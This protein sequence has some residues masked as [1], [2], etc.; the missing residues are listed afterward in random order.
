MSE[1]A[2]IERKLIQI[3]NT[4]VLMGFFSSLRRKWMICRQGG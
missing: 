4:T 1:T 3:S 2:T